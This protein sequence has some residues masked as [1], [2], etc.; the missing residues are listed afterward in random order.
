[1][2]VTISNQRRQGSWTPSI[3]GEDMEY[4]DKTS[5]RNQSPNRAQS[6]ELHCA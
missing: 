3:W 1:M 4:I 2:T 6:Q 5:Q